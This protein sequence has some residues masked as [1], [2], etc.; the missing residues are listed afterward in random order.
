[1]SSNHS[2][3]YSTN[4]TAINNT[5]PSFTGALAPEDIKLIATV[6]FSLVSSLGTVGNF[7]VILTLVR[8]VDMR[9]PC[10]LFIANISFTDL[11]VSLVMAPLRII[12]QH[13]G[14]WIFG[15]VLC[16]VIA[17]LQDTLASASVLSHT[18]IALERYRAIVA[19][20][21]PRLNKRKVKISILFIWIGCYLGTSFPLLFF[22]K[23]ELR[24]GVTTCLAS[25]FPKEDRYIFSLYLVVFFILIPLVCQVCCYIMVI[26]VL[27]RK[28]AIQDHRE[29]TSTTAEIQIQTSK[30][31]VRTKKRLIRMLVVLMLIFQLCYLPRAFIMLIYEFARPLT[32]H[33]AFPYVNISTM[34]LFYVKHVINPLVLYC[35]SRDYRDGFIGLCMCRTLQD[36]S[37]QA[38]PESGK[39]SSN[40]TRL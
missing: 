35:M 7:L 5:S 14:G 36:F 31:R 18:A 25:Q 17:P 20:F 37:L 34:L 22:V 13:T 40:K 15:E 11:I 30:Q 19:P 12:E 38:V 26:R 33:E 16:Y 29:S 21:K 6:F 2:T 1:M 24:N 32:T 3:N 4:A 9:T 28:D 27:R 10:N 8:W 23:H 39:K